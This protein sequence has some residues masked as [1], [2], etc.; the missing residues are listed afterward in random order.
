MIIHRLAWIALVSVIVLVLAGATVRVT[1]SG[2]GCPDWPTCW[3]CLIP[4]TRAD[5]IDVEKLDLEKFKRHAERKGIDPDT[6]TRETI[7]ESFN[8]VQTWIE[9]SNRLASLPLG[10]STLL[11]A[12]FSF[13]AKKNRWWIV[14]LSWFCLFDVL[15]NAVM[16]AMVVRSGLQPGIITLHMALAFLL[17]AVLATLIW[18]SRPDESRARI[19]LATR[20]KLLVVS[21][22]FF[23]CLFGE[24]LMGSQLRERTD[25]MLI[26][27]ETEGGMERDQWGEELE[28]TL[29]YKI[30]RSFSWTLLITSS[31]LLFWTRQE[32]GLSAP[33]PKLIFGMVIAMMVMGIILGHV[34]IY[35]TIQ[36]LHV[37][38][39]AVLLAVTWHWVVRIWSVGISS[40]PGNLPTENSPTEHAAS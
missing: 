3:G 40:P 36:V 14:L 9:F 29:I 23:G 15:F 31:L 11:L 16:G 19:S 27:S 28:K 7:L 13:R 6:I 30:H 1:G 32:K 17:I 21:L 35:Q 20:K 38:T 5:Q 34:S 37:G 12:L 33:E 22:V 26:T 18:L 39:T 24:G 8:P 4:P 25:E 10:I 2:L